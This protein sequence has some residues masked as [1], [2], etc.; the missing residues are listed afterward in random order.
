MEEIKLFSEIKKPK[1]LELGGKGYSLVLLFKNGFN[2]PN[3]FIIFS[4]IYFRYLYENNIGSKINKILIKTDIS[5]FIEK[6]KQIKQIILDGKIPTEIKLTIEKNIN[7]LKFKSLSIR[8]SAICE[9]S[10]NNSYAGLFD[11]FLNIKS[12]IDQVLNYIIK[13]WA[14]LYNDRAIAYSIK[15]G[16]KM[17]EGMAVVIQEMVPAEFSGITFTSH[18]FNRKNLLIE[19][20]YGIGNMIVGGK[21]Q[22][23]S[24]TINRENLKLVGKKIGIKEKASI[25]DNQYNNKLIEINKKISKNQTIANKYIIKIAEVCLEIEKFFSYPQDIEWCLYNNNLWIL[26]SRPITV[27]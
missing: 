16:L 11:S 26:Q 24:F 17:P 8:S 12:N 10:P 20:S 14:S 19:V 7:L 18:P 27:I 3:G 4:D 5:N 23:D 21:I 1:T 13:I 22:P 2:V 25:I 9:D 6:S 15:K